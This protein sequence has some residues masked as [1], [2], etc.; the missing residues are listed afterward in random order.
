MTNVILAYDKR[1]LGIMVMITIVVMITTV[2]HWQP[3]LTHTA[4]GLYVHSFSSIVFC[5]H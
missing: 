5:V 3:F 2:Y 1:N 4:R